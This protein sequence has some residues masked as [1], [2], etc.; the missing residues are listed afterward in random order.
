MIRLTQQ[1]GLYMKNNLVKPSF[2]NF[3]YQMYTWGKH[4][5]QSRHPQSNLDSII[6][7]DNKD[8]VT[9]FDLI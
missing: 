1:K 3:Q 5:V 4:Q 8:L 2:A 6:H 9:L 7:M